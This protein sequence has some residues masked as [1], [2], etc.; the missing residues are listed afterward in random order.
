MWSIS[1]D[2]DDGSKDLLDQCYFND[3]QQHWSNHMD[4]VWYILNNLK[5]PIGNNSSFRL[6][7]QVA[8][9]ILIMP[10][11]NVTVERVYSLTKNNKQQGTECNH[12]DIKGSLS[13]ILAI[14]LDRT[15]SK[16]ACYNFR[17]D[18]SLLVSTKKSYSIAQW[19]SLQQ[20]KIDIL[21][22]YFIFKTSKKFCWKILLKYMSF[23][24]VYLFCWMYSW[25]CLIHMVKNKVL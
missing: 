14:K 11:S 17:A 13:S 9:L 23:V 7:F 21:E 5:S 22:R 2:Y 10:Y 25:A 3:D 24:F 16:F 20:I 4:T 6:L 1:C 18:D 15:E 8:K 12:L 19:S